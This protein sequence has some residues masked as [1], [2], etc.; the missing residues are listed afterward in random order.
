[1]TVNTSKEAIVAWCQGYLADVL[2][3]PAAAVDPG[4]TFDRLGV[5]SAVAV[6]LLINVEERYGVELP[7]QALFDNRTL[8]AV[9]DYVAAHA[10]PE[11]A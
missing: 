8:N 6:S 4:V 5:G 11:A 1:V 3:V 2:G 9:A 10:L 7:A